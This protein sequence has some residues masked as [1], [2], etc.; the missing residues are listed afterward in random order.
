M[1]PNKVGDFTT[2][3]CISGTCCSLQAT[4]CQNGADFDAPTCTCRCKPGFQGDKCENKATTADAVIRKELAVDA[5]TMALFNTTARPDLDTTQAPLALAAEATTPAPQE[6]KMTLYIAAGGGGLLV[7]AAAA[8][9][10]TKKK[11]P[12]GDP[13]LAGMEGM[14]GMDLSGMDLSALGMDPAAA[15]ANPL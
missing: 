11:K 1:C 9:F 6:N 15:N 3:K 4:D 12:A 14:E 8:Y 13:L 2:E 5:A 7:I 10:L